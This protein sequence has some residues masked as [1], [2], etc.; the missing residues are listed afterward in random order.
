MSLKFSRAGSRRY[1]DAEC[2]GFVFVIIMEFPIGT[3]ILYS[4]YSIDV[5]IG[6]IKNRLY[7][8]NECYRHVKK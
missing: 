3:S 1:Q 5:L 6:M 4:L 7:V 8:L 2:N